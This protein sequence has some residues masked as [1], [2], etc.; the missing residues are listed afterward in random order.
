MTNSKKHQWKNNFLRLANK[1]P[2]CPMNTRKS[3]S[4]DNYVENVVTTSVVA[5]YALIYHEARSL[6]SNR[7][8]KG[9][10]NNA[11]RASVR[12]F[13]YIPA[14]RCTAFAVHARM[15][16]RSLC[17]NKR[18]GRHLERIKWKRGGRRVLE[19]FTSSWAC[20]RCIRGVRWKTP[21]PY[22][23]R[24]SPHLHLLLEKSFNNPVHLRGSIS[25]RNSIF[26]SRLVCPSF[27]I[28]VPWQAGKLKCSRNDVG[29]I[30]VW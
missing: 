1:G 23:H 18:R 30:F 25:D 17:C 4:G 15:F 12:I 13:V 21:I 5:N 11:R 6:G 19:A 2:M 3:I 16:W 28:F 9:K 10:I 27:A 22:D 26:K 7:M 14:R 24:R 20:S 29:F 8:R